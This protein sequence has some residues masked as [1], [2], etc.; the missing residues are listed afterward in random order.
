MGNTVGGILEWD[1]K[2]TEGKRVEQATRDANAA[3]ARMYEQTREDQEPWRAAGADALEGLSDQSNFENFSMSDFEKDP[4]Y[5]FRMDEGAKA[6][7]RSAAAKGG[8]NSGRTMKELSRYGQGFASNE[9]S[10]AY[11]RFN[12]DRD[13][14]YNRLASLAGIGQVATNQVGA[15]N[16]NFANQYGANRVAG[17]QA[18]AAGN[19][20]G[21]Q[22]ANEAHAQ[23]QQLMMSGAGMMMSDEREKENISEVSK[24]DLQE[25][26]QVI[27]P[28]LFKYKNEENGK[29][30]FVG[31]MAQD[32][33][34]SKLGKT[35]VIENSEGVKMIDQNRAIMLLLATVGA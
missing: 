35:L 22:A 1:T 14:K 10:N 28:M 25:L 8:L 2:K 3:Q 12:T 13:S 29:G 31:V 24:A 6:V 27:R 5:Q 23:D 17:S 4:G 26:S 30:E 9:F 32:L 33:E 34:K 11:N 21:L 7:E 16:Q 15:A 18:R 19:I 20:G